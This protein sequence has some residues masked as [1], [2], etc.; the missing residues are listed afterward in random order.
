M[1]KRKVIDSNNL[2]TKMPLHL[3]LT[4]ILIIKVFNTSE[5]WCGVMY[6]LLALLWLS[7]IYRRFTETDHDI[8]DEN[9]H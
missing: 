9:N 6:T 4:I 7:Y 2:P 5:L 3:S 1:K 8:F